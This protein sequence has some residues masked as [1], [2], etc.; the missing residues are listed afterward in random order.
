MRRLRRGL[1]FCTN[2]EDGAEFISCSY[3]GLTLLIVFFWPALRLCWRY[4]LLLQVSGGPTLTWP[5]RCGGPSSRGDSWAGSW[6]GGSWATPS[7][8]GQPTRSS[9]LWSSSTATGPTFRSSSTATITETVRVRPFLV[10]ITRSWK[11]GPTVSHILRQ[12]Q[13]LNNAL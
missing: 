6:W 9:P 8:S 12:L 7:R 3:V 11:W 13:R 2:S 5:G 4:F 10:S 1:M